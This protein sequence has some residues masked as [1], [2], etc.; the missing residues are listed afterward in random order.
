MGSKSLC[1]RSG[2]M[3]LER[4]VEELVLETSAGM[5]KVRVYL[6]DGRL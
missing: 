3:V 6:S 1:G 2:E 5:C 4:I